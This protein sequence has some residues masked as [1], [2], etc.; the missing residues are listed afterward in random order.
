MM[1]IEHMGMIFKFPSNES[2][3]IKEMWLI[4]KNH[5]VE[6]IKEKARLWYCKK[7]IG[8]QYDKDVMECT[9]QLDQTMSAYSSVS[10]K[11]A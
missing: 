8:C 7:Y 11:N 5:N 9:H 10:S 2:F 4:A 3:N 1:F 6:H